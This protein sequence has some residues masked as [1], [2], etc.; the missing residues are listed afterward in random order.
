MRKEEKGQFAQISK[1][2]LTYLQL[3]SSDDS[4]SLAKG[5]AEQ[6][7]GKGFHIGKLAMP[8]GL[9]VSIFYIQ[10]KY[11]DVPCVQGPRKDTLGEKE[12]LTENHLD[13]LEEYS[14]LVMGKSTKD[15]TLNLY[16][17]WTV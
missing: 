3:Q 9:F 7:L 5:K 8:W 17:E 11:Y 12:M 1:R 6:N 15:D 14:L 10:E 13:R 16:S 4:E 2:H